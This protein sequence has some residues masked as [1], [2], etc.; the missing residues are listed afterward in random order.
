MVESNALST[1]LVRLHS[2]PVEAAE[3]YRGLQQRLVR[4]FNLTAASDP[5]RLVDETIKRLAQRAAEDAATVYADN[6]NDP[7]IAEGQSPIIHPAA[8]LAFGIARKVLQEDLSRSQPND[9]AVRDWID[10]TTNAPDPNRERRLAI[11]RSCLSRLSPERRHLLETY[12]DW[13]PS[14]KAE[15]HLQLAQSLG[16]NLNAL[17]NR[18]LR[19]RVQLESCVRRKQENTSRRSK[20]GRKP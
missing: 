6:A 15:H 7:A 13:S 4:F 14:N 19:S 1:L 9:Q 3:A 18:V 8:T 20:R 11:L 16:L 2:D 12:Y 10:Q 5:Q 17:R